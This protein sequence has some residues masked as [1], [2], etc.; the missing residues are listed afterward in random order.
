MLDRTLTQATINTE[1]NA[2]QEQ[3]AEKMQEKSKDLLA[4]IDIGK[5]VSVSVDK[6]DRGPLDPPVVIGIVT[7][8]S[9][10]HLMYDIGTRAGHLTIRMARNTLTA[11]GSHMKLDDIPA[12]NISSMRQLVRELSNFGGQGYLHCSCTTAC[13]TN[14]CKCKKSSQI[15][16]SRCHPGRN[17]ENHE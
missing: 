13:K 7:G 3:S 9:E 10:D 2:S 4:P 16:N 6:V 1:V 14:K 17:C 12:N 5:C 11:I 8:F 15:C